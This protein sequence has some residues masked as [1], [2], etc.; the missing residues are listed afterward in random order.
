[1]FCCLVAVVSMSI[2]LVGCG[3]RGMPGSSIELRQQQFDDGLRKYQ[4]NDY[5]T[6]KAEFDKALSGGGL[7]AD[8][9]SDAL[10]MR[11]ECSIHL[12]DVTTA[13]KDIEIAEKAATDTARLNM[14]KGLL[15]RKNG[16]AA[17]AAAFFQAALAENPEL[18]IPQ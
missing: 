6:A 10:L 13:Q 17:G 12:G 16:D 5:S 15:A 9:Y 3:D 1:M 14:V 2:T 18:V 8:Q 11:A 7:S 4:L